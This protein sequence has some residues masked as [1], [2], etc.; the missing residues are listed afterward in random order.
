MVRTLLG[1]IGFFLWLGILYPSHALAQAGGGEGDFEGEFEGEFT[2]ES[3]PYFGLG[4][5]YTRTLVL[6][7]YDDLNS[8]S[9]ALSLGDFSGP[10]NVDFFGLTF[11]PGIAPN[12]RFGLYAGIGTKQL[13]RQVRVQDTGIYTRTIY[14]TQVDGAL[15][16]DYA[17]PI[18]SAFTIFPGTMLGYGRSTVGASQ[19]RN[20]GARF[21]DIFSGPIFDGDRNASLSNVNR[22]A[23]ALSYHLFFYPA[24]N[25]E[26]TLTPNIM[27]RLGAGYNTT[28]SA[29]DWS[30]EGGGGL[31]DAP[32]VSTRGVAVQIGIFLGLFQH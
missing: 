9:R 27:M 20:P 13:T 14:Y 18:S 4:I 7:D 5:G 12:L 17:I 3:L 26:Y 2:S 28:L 25:F 1:I 11:T 19:I 24:V 29:T 23:R 15:Q 6:A 31:A 30:D 8:V 10:F 32:D 16:V 21:H 22:F